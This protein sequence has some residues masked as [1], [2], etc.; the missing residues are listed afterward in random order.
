[1]N[2]SALVIGASSLLIACDPP[3]PLDRVELATG[4]PRVTSPHYVDRGTAPEARIRA[5]IALPIRDGAVLDEEIAALYDPQSA[6]YRNYLSLEQWLAAYAPSDVDVVAI[7]EW[8][9]SGGLQ[10]AR[11]AA[12]RLLLEVTGS[13]ADFD[14]RFATDIHALTKIDDDEYVTFGTVHP[15]F[16]PADIARRIESIVVADPAADD[17]PLPA[18]TGSISTEPPPNAAGLVVAQVAHAYGF[19]SLAATGSGTTIAIVGGAGFKRIDVQSFWRSQG[20][21]RSDP[22]LIETM[23]PLS[24]RYTETTLDIEW[25][26]ALAPGATILVFA[27]PDT[28]ETSLVYT[29]N[30]AIADGRAQVV[31]DSFAHREDITPRAIRNQY[32]ASA[33][34]AAALGMTVIAAGGDSGEPDVPASSPL[35]TSV[36]GTVLTLD[37]AGTRIDEVAWKSSGSG[38]SSSF[39]APAWQTVA[40]KRA[41][42]DVAI[43]V[44]PYWMYSFGLW[45]AFGGTSFSAPVFSA[46]IAVVDS[47]RG[48]AGKPPVG[49]INRALYTDA[50][51]QAA[52]RDVVGGETASYRAEPGWDYPTGWGTPDASRLAEALP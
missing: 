29:F 17:S 12:N 18:E 19:D 37:T 21:E 4:L 9:E 52:L 14:E 43:S 50:A 32:H 36:G 1:V 51:V 3:Q 7:S 34:M 8:L 48:A 42:S 10:V 35:V 28:H 22:M 46:M 13:A 39:E 44:G 30:A 38:Q 25:S 6:R 47:A 33:R 15:V 5:L 27:G 45:R 23:E 20:I 41:V 26:G 2:F 31:N 11:V 24:T 40:G 49:L 16:A